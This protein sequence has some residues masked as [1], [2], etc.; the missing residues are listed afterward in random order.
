MLMDTTANTKRI[1]PLEMMGPYDHRPLPLPRTC[2]LCGGRVAA[3]A[4][5]GGGGPA[6]ASRDHKDESG[7]VKL[8]PPKTSW[9]TVMSSVLSVGVSCTRCFA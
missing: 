3:G 1:Y 7:L 2:G 4:S 9:L 5:V 8:K 6:S